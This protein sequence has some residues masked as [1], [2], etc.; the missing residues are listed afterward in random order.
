MAFNRTVS[1][2]P[3]KMISDELKLALH[4]YNNHC[5]FVILFFDTLKLLV[6]CNEKRLPVPGHFFNARLAEKGLKTQTEAHTISEKISK[7]ISKN[8]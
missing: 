3:V 5:V 6:K 4:N 7:K 2:D 1:S 8:K